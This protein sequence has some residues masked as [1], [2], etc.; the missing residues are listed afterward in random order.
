VKRKKYNK[1]KKKKENHNS[2]IGE[3]K[4]KKP[5]IYRKSLP[6]FIISWLPFMVMT[7][8]PVGELAVD[9]TAHRHRALHQLYVPLLYQNR[10]RLIAKRFH[11]RLRKQLA[12]HRMLDLTVQIH[13]RRH[14]FQ[15]LSLSMLR[16]APPRS[17]I[18]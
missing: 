16:S 8:P 9:I 18:S 4:K 7:L 10:S 13:T 11:L 1:K 15:S 14:R 2:K 17:P 3:K 6:T 5:L 12:L